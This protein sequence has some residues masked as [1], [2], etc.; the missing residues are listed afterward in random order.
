MTP[1]LDKPSRTLTV[2]IKPNAARK[3]SAGSKVGKSSSPAS[4]RASAG[5]KIRK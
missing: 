1:K 3:A 4:R 2:T 5:T